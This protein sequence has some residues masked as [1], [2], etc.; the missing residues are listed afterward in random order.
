MDAEYR[1]LLVAEERAAATEERLT[2]ER[3]DLVARRCELSDAEVKLVRQDSLAVAEDVQ[4]RLDRAQ[5]A[6]EAARRRE[7]DLLLRL[8]QAQARHEALALLESKLAVAHD[9]MATRKEEDSVFGD[10]AKAFGRDGIQAMLIDQSL[11]RV[12]HTA[13][14]MLDRMTG[15]R[16]HVNLATQRQSASGKVTETLDIRISDEVGTRDYEM[17]SG[18]EAFRVDFAL[19]IALARLSPSVRATLPR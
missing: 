7:S 14:D 1:K 15:G 19:R 3:Q 13:N 16:I 8:G 12:E 2:R 10:L 11:P 5:E 6:V 9:E 18:G 4:P 17:Y